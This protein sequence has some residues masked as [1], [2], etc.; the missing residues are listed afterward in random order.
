MRNLLLIIILLISLKT[1]GQEIKL[2]SFTKSDCTE[3]QE[4]YLGDS[5][6]YKSHKKDT[7]VI[8]LSTEANCCTT[9]IPSVSLDD[10]IL[11]LSYNELGDYCNCICYY[12]Y[13]YTI[14]GIK[15]DDY[16]VH[17]KNKKLATQN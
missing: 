17:F 4:D 9:I 7:L 5:I 6:L 13:Q 14:V 2:A 12:E 8:K 3:Q 1:S 11:N 15:K 10:G 16:L